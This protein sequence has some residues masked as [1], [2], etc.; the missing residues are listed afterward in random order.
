MRRWW[1][2]NLRSR[3]T[4]WYVGVLAVLLVVYATLVF[5]FQYVVLTKQIVH[6]EIQDVETVE[7]LLFFDEAG[8]LQLRQDYYSRPQSHLLI[9]RMMEV[10]DPSGIVLYRSPTLKGMSLGGPTRPGEGGADFGERLTRLDDGT[11]VLLISHI[12]G[13]DNRQLLIRL[14]YSLA[15]L[16]E[17][18]FQFLAVLLIA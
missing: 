6:D 1:P 14:G 2:S 7:G 15:P 12:H 16:R 3:L 8:T 11:H 9:D 10:R 17:R 5:A 4:F 18:M 13:M